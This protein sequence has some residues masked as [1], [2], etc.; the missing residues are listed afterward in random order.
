MKRMSAGGAFALVVATALLAGCSSSHPVNE[1]PE[2]RQAPAEGLCTAPVAHE[3]LRITES[4]TDPRY[5]EPYLL[6]D[7]ASPPIEML[8]VPHYVVRGGF[9][10][11]PAKFAFYFPLA[12]QY[13][14]RFFQGPI[15]QLR[16]TGELATHSELVFAFNSGAYVVQANPQ[17][18]GALTARDALSGNF[19]PTLMGYRL[20]AAAAKYSR[21]V[22]AQLYGHAH[23]PYGYIYG[24]SGGAYMVLSAAEHTLGVWDGFAPTV[25]GHPLAIPNDFSVRLNAL[26]VLN[27]RNKWPEVVDAID[28]GG[29][30]DPYA[31]LNAEEAAALREATLLGFPPRAWYQ[32]ATIGGG[33]FLP[34]ARYALDLDPTYVDDFWT[35]PGYLGTDP[36]A[37]VA[38]AR[39]RFPA[40]V[41]A[42]TPPVAPPD[43]ATLG[44]G[45]NAYIIGQYS[46]G[47]PRQLTLSGLPPG[48]LANDF[49]LVVESGAA[50]GKFLKIGAVDRNTNSVRIGGG[51]DVEAINQIAVGDRLRLDNSYVLALQTYHRHQDPRD[52]DYYGWRQFQDA[53]GAP[54]FPQRPVNVGPVAARN[55]S[56]SVA[57]G[58]FNGKM[59]MLG[60]LMDPDAFPWCS[61]W[62]RSK[63][64]KLRAAA[65]RELDDDFRLWFTDHAQHGAEGYD[66][67]RT[68]NYTGVAEQALRDLSRWAEEGVAPPAGTRYSVVDT[69]IVLPAGAAERLGIQPVVTLKANGADRAEVAVNEP[70]DFTA[71]VEVP[72]GAGELVET[73][74][75]YEGTGSFPVAIPNPV[76]GITPDPNAGAVGGINL[77]PSTVTLQGSHGYSKP[78]TYFALLRATSQRDGDSSTAH[79]RIQ[80]IARVR[81]VVQ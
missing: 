12:S 55:A 17:Q 49:H 15:H 78:G 62:Y 37:S 36:S 21:V 35:R 8:P 22:A 66:Q 40:T 11:T 53:R 81:V 69:Q 42:A 77:P 23:R 63:A 7:L 20:A 59:I 28:P 16:L 4:C 3:P 25:T 74:W 76:P 10:G 46:T 26:R 57:T 54:R 50:A 75:D 6:V 14:G 68:V 39:V 64:R 33:A 9:R 72:P 34:T 5:D 52:A 31:T 44:D 73:E 38:A 80:N 47:W 18:D 51:E 1:L 60:S 61:D 56:G 58:R 45:Y 79:G 13:Q 70:V 32:Y 24:G 71:T 27:Q 41:T 30:G 43:Y 67:T 2:D 65:G 48:D 29:S 19:D